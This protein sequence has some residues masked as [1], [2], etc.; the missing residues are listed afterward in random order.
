MPT[1][2]DQF[3]VTLGIDP[4]GFTEGQRKA[5]QSLRALE[6]NA[7][8]SAQ[9]IE[10]SGASVVTFFRGLEQPIG[11]LRQHFEKLA[12]FTAT[13]QRNLA[14]LAQQA[15]RTGQEVE[16]G[17]MAGAVGLRALGVAGLTA[18]AA[19]TALEKIRSSATD[20]ARNLFGTSLSAGGAGI[21]IDRFTA[22][23]QALLHSGNVPEGET[24]GFLRRLRTSQVQ[25]QHGDP[26]AAA[27]MAANLAKIGVSGVNAFTDSPEQ[28]LF[29]IAQRFHQVSQD[30]A[31]G[32]GGM[33]GQS[34]ALSTAL[35]N[36]GDAGLRAQVQ[37]EQHR[38]ATDKQTQAAADLVKAQANLDISWTNLQRRIGE[39]IDPALA[40][41]DD[42]LSHL[43]DTITG[44]R[45]ERML[46]TL[47]LSVVPGGAA[48][49]QGVN[50]AEDAKGL[51]GTVKSWLGFGGKSAPTSSSSSGG[52]IS[53]TGPAAAADDITAIRNAVA[54]AGGNEQTQAA[55]LA[56]FAAEDR[57]LNPSGLEEG[58]SGA[59]GVGGKGGA[60]WAQWTA[61]RRRQLEAFG[62]TGTNPAA[63][64]AASQKMLYWEL[65][66]N[67]TFAAMV[68]RMNAAGSASEAARIS[69]LTFEQGGGDASMFGYGRFSQ[70]GLDA[71]HS[72]GAEN[73]LAMIRSQGAGTGSGQS[74]VDRSISTNTGDIHTHVY[75]ADT[76][77]GYRL[78]GQI[79]RGIS[80]Q[81]LVN[82]SN[83]GQ[84]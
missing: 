51:W 55:F 29:A 18:V 31:V 20:T 28:I 70:A 60:S 84:E 23:S 3:I 38:A 48:I 82:Q 71:F 43:L 15:R 6:E 57:N 8:R 54:A 4:S 47:G 52:A 2:I 36:L 42:L 63:D 72:R 74:S 19:F 11:T 46:R 27:E 7:S 53:G 10:A 78:G 44:E 76:S 50:A 35:H 59:A 16:A 37:L 24:Q 62:W 34:D 41:F 14:A 49:A 73:Y 12:T 79:G 77:D 61:S 58:I 75:G 25:A 9:R 56:N 68:Q 32:L 69:G 64:R 45:A 1:V 13:P 40:R 22:L 80:D 33:V 67:P 5:A 83:A 66:T 21:S 30:T 65:T 26:A 39:Q 81:L 17:A